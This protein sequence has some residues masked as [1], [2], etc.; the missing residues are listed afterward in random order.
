M[1]LRTPFQCQGALDDPDERLRLAADPVRRLDP[2]SRLVILDE[3]ETTASQR[4]H[5]IDARPLAE[6]LGALAVH[7]IARDAARLGLVVTRGREVEPLAPGVW[8]VPD[9]RLFGPADPN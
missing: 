9:W 4:V 8:A 6:V 7:G 2:G 5:R 1:L 3:G